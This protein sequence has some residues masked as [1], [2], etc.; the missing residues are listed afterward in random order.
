M[1]R[2]SFDQKP[3]RKMMMNTWGANCVASPSTDTQAGRDILAKY[4]DTGPRYPE[5][6]MKMIRK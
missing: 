3:F 6:M 1:V 2:V 5:E 4:P